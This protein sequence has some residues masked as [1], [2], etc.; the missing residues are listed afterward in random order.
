[1][2]FEY[3][4]YAVPEDQAEAFVADYLAASAVLMRSPF[5]RNVDL[6]RCAEDPM[7]FILRIEWTSAQD[8]LHGFRKSADFP[9]FLSHI[10]RYMPMI[11]EMRHYER[12][13]VLP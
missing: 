6:S 11:Q 12:L 3:L 4:R 9:E 2:T 7:Q 1:M 13:L 8:H 5:A 10:R